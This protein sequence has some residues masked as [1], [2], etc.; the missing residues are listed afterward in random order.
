MRFLEKNTYFISVTRRLGG[1]ASGN[2]LHFTVIPKQA[3]VDIETCSQ[4]KKLFLEVNV[5]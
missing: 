5:L 2:G 4:S 1:V 3:S